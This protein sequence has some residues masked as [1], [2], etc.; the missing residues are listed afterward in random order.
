MIC[1]LFCFQT[2]LADWLPSIGKRCRWP[3]AYSGPL[4]L[5]PY[6]WD[7]LTK[8]RLLQSCWNWGSHLLMLWW[9][10]IYF[11]INFVDSSIQSK[12]HL[13]VWVTLFLECGRYCALTRTTKLTHIVKYYLNYYFLFILH[14]NKSIRAQMIF[15]LDTFH[16]SI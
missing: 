9:R 5:R 13:Y 2:V 16:L 4:K 15:L 11:N 14:Q 10:F 3:A 6:T 1:L 7:L 8:I 12:G